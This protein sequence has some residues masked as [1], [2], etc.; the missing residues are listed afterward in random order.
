MEKQ[1]RKSRKARRASIDSD[2]QPTQSFEDNRGIETIEQFETFVI[3]YLKRNNDAL[4]IV[5]DANLIQIIN[6]SNSAAI[7]FLN[8]LMKSRGDSAFPT[9][10]EPET[11][12]KF[13]SLLPQFIESDDRLNNS[14]LQATTSL[15]TKAKTK[16]RRKRVHF[17]I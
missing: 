9:P 16:T 6:I 10:I 3:N 15:T 5:H 11:E 13:M 4:S 8:R 7:M 1:V 2:I 12:K 17:A 14:I